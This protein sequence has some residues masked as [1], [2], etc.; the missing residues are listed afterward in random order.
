MMIQQLVGLQ[1]STR[2]SLLMT[3]S[4]FPRS[5]PLAVSRV[6]VSA[7]PI[8]KFGPIRCVIALVPVR[9]YSRPRVIQGGD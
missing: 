4:M 3:S 6:D 9:H 5:P 2:A 1:P 7:G 8:D